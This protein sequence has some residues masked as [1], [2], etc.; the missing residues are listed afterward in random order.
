MAPDSVISSSKIC[1][2]KDLLI[3]AQNADQML[4]DIA[5]QQNIKFGWGK[6]NINQEAPVSS[7]ELL[8]KIFIT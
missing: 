8:P 1:L 4:S 5:E 7:S 6:V 2:F 3:L